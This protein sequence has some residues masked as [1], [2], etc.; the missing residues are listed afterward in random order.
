MKT[1]S[2]SNPDSADQASMDAFREPR[3]Y[4]RFW[5]MSQMSPRSNGHVSPE[6]ESVE[7][8]MSAN[9]TQE[10]HRSSEVVSFDDWQI[11]RHFPGDEN[12][13]NHHF[14]AY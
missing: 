4:P 14:T 6:V 12:A 9:E 2:K 10:D 8:E 13:H 7:A 3:L 5:D 11:N 1:K